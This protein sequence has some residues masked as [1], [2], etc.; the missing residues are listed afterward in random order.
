MMMCQNIIGM[1]VWWCYV[2][3]RVEIGCAISVCGCFFQNFYSCR[4]MLNLLRKNSIHWKLWWL[5]LRKQIIKNIFFGLSFYW[6]S[7]VVLCTL[8]WHSQLCWNKWRWWWG[9]VTS[10]DIFK[11]STSGTTTHCWELWS[12]VKSN[13]GRNKGHGKELLC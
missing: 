13:I 2:G 8:L 1:L 12:Y 10:S 3:W 6:C 5:W 11:L 7:V 4:F 9:V